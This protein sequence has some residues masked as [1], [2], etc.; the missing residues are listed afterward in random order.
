MKVYFNIKDGVINGLSRFPF[1]VSK[2]FTII[3][4]EITEEK[5]KMGVDIF[6]F[7][8]GKINEVPPPEV[9]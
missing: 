4:K 2:G 1:E 8:N 9:D 6:V 7:E 5:F 3:E